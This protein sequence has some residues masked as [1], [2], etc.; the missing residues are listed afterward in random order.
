M[1][2]N[3]HK[4][5]GRFSILLKSGLR[6]LLLTGFVFVAGCGNNMSDLQQWVAKVKAEKH[7]KIEPIP[8]IKPQVTFKYPQHTRDPF[9][10]SVL[11]SNKQAKS[12]SS[13]KIDKNRT[14]EYL[15]SFPL[16]TLKMVGTIQEKGLLWALI[17]TPDG[18]IQ[19]VT[20]GNYMGE[21]DGKI[22][23]ISSNAIY[24]RE[25]VPDGFGGFK[26]RQTK[27]AISG[28]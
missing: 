22:L 14:P 3:A 1:P 10:S 13:I 2:A 25:I 17:Q 15:E 19:R 26:E 23:R 20:T 18:T 9:D 12:D 5:I 28:Q 7:A 21:H 4:P 6:L 27:V 16:S 24:L 11:L 8:E